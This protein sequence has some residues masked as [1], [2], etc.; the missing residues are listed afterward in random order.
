MRQDKGGVTDA[1]P[2][3]SERPFER[4]TLMWTHSLTTALPRQSA[5]RNMLTVDLLSAAGDVSKCVRGCGWHAHL[6]RV[7]PVLYYMVRQ[8]SLL[9]ERTLL[10]S[11]Q[12]APFLS[13][14]CQ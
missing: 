12:L 13:L 2:R 14:L 7:L 3:F 1:L 10:A 5:A 8:H 6:P 9:S 4:L 11:S